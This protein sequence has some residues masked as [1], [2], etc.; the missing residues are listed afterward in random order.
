MN[1]GTIRCFITG[2]VLC[3]TLTA[4]ASAWG[5]I[6]QSTREWTPVPGEYPLTC[7]EAPAKAL[8]IFFDP[9]EGNEE[10][11]LKELEACRD[12]RQS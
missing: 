5:Y 10:T 6:G 3:A 1:R 9:L 11:I 4:Y 7:P 2:F 12:I 8:N